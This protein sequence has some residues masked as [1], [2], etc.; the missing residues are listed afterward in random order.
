MER[1]KTAGI[2]RQ[3]SI[4]TMTG[5]F[6]EVLIELE[7]KPLSGSYHTTVYIPPGEPHEKLL[8]ALTGEMHKTEERRYEYPPKNSKLKL[9][10]EISAI[11][12]R[13]HLRGDI[14]ENGMVIFCGIEKTTDYG[15][16]RQ[17]NIAIEP[18]TP[19]KEFKFVVGKKFETVT[20][21]SLV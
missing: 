9:Q 11:I 19:V 16:T 3:S 2:Q 15:L 4:H 21:K 20:A 8:A 10:A 18:P 13:F 1:G 17:I 5:D 7:R 14:P 12:F 6:E